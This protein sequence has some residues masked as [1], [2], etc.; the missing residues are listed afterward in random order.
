MCITAL[1]IV[2][3]HWKQLKCPLTGKW[4]NKLRYTQA[5]TYYA[6]GENNALDISLTA[7]GTPVKSLYYILGERGSKH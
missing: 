5:I 1:I 7:W 6:E 3:K 4:L 2:A